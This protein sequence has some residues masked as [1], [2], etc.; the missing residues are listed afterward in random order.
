MSFP[1]FWSAGFFAHVKRAAFALRVVAFPVLNAGGFAVVFHPPCAR[2]CVVVGAVVIQAGQQVVVFE[3]F[4]HLRRLFLAVVAQQVVLLRH[5]HFVH[6]SGVAR[7]AFL[8]VTLRCRFHT[9]GQFVPVTPFV[10]RQVQPGCYRIPCAIEAQPVVRPQFTHECL[11]RRR[12]FVQV[13]LPR[14]FQVIHG[15]IGR[16]VQFLGQG[17][18]V[19]VG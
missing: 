2:L 8:P 4:L 16:D 5:I 15:V 14:G 18:R 9:I 6:L 13:F 7:P 11:R 3:D 12:E 17:I 19:I 10:Q 1:F